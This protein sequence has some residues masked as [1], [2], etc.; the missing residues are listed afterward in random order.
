MKLL[1]PCRKSTKS[2]NGVVSEVTNSTN[3]SLTLLPQKCSCVVQCPWTDVLQT[4]QTYRVCPAQL[5][6]LRTKQWRKPDIFWV[7]YSYHSGDCQKVCVHCRWPCHR[8]GVLTCLDIWKP[9]TLLV[10]TQSDWLVRATRHGAIVDKL[11]KTLNLPEQNF[12]E[13]KRTC[14]EKSHVRQLFLWPSRKS[15][16]GQFLLL[17]FPFTPSRKRKLSSPCFLFRGTVIILCRLSRKKSHGLS[18]LMFSAAVTD[19]S[20]YNSFYPFGR[21]HVL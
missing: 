4:Y 20:S 5:C 19:I 2:M 10:C 3:K 7:C 17:L 14:L 11:M 1:M 18:V 9:Q 13:Q 6:S 12:L 15:K 8:R 16:P 21:L